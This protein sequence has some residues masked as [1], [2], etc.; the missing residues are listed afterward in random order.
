MIFCDL[1]GVLAD[2]ES[3][4]NGKEVVFDEKN[5]DVF[6]VIKPFPNALEFLMTL[7]TLDQTRIL[8]SVPKNEFEQEYKKDKI[9]WCDKYLGLQ[10][11]EIILCYREEKQNYAKGNVLIDD[12]HVNTKEWIDAG[13]YSILH[14]SFDKTLK[15]LDLIFAVK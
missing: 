2:F 14:S 5:R 1:D 9:D 12:W 15:E 6:R 4:F 3:Y 13:G 11:N 8:S 10:E 7:K